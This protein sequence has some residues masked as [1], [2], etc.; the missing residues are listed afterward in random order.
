MIDSKC[1]GLTKRIGMTI[2]I[3]IML[4]GCGGVIPTVQTD[5]QDL[6]VKSFLRAVERKDTKTVE[7]YIKKGMDVNAREDSDRN[8]LWIATRNDDANMVKTLIKAG[9]DLNTRYRYGYSILHVSVEKDAV[10]AAEVLINAGADLEAKTEQGKTPLFISASLGRKT[11]PLLIRAGADLNAA[12]N[13]GETAL[14]SAAL[15]GE[16][17]SIRMLVG[18]KANVDTSDRMG[19][20]A[21][22]NAAG[23]LRSSMASFKVKE[24]VVTE[25]V[26][27]LL[28]AGA[29]AN[30]KTKNEGE[31]ALHAAAKEG[32][33]GAAELLIKAGANVNAKTKLDK[34]TPL[35]EAAKDGNSELVKLLLKSGAKRKTKDRLGRT[36]AKWGSDH[37]QIV[38]ILGGKLS[39]KTAKAKKVSPKNKEQARKRLYELGYRTFD[40]STFVMSAHKG[41]LDAVKA[42]LDY[43]LSLES[44][45]PRD[46][47][48]TPLL[49]ASMTPR[50]PELGIFLVEAGADVNVKDVNGSTPLIWAAQKCGMKD[51]VRALVKAGAD[52][53]A[54]AA[55]GA[56]PLMMAK[57]FKC[58]EII[59][60]LEKAGARK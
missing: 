9:A 43:G 28:S 4:T 35:M 54:K 42:F 50:S 12:N 53:N 37:P 38:T 15:T 5:V 41:D 22:I 17:E 21:L 20:T 45:D 8:A 1:M 10:A 33:T 46:H 24:R 27:V 31:T 25:M 23:M 29:D 6:S 56:T 60:I 39:R 16:L 13:D 52:V 58:T 14:M 44:K 48:T 36:A 40:E 32:H 18:S 34:F 51:L 3:A 55:G 11:T 7:R 47:A 30:A 59:E 19:R 26:E 57:T 2:L 49:A